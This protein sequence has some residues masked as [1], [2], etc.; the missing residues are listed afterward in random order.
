MA[1]S[2]GMLTSSSGQYQASLLC[3]QFLN[4][5]TPRNTTLADIITQVLETGGPDGLTKFL[6]ESAEMELNGMLAPLHPAKECVEPDI[7]A[8][9]AKTLAIVDVLSGAT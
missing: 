5:Q 3:R 4:T 9:T 8:F 7:Q 1:V 6:F 2:A